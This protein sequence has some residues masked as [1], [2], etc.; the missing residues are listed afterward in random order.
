MSKFID[1]L[2]A[3][4]VDKHALMTLFA[5]VLRK[6]KLEK[7]KRKTTD[8]KFMEHYLPVMV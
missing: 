4:R 1:N 3:P 5:D 6:S 2:I 7:W 8:Q